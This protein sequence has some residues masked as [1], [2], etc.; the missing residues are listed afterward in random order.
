M[1]TIA[2]FES[3]TSLLRIHSTVLYAAAL[4][5]ALAVQDGARA[6]TLLEAPVASGGNLEGVWTADSMAF[7]V[8]TAPELAVLTAS[9]TPS[10]EPL[11]GL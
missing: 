7:E 3:R 11:V 2:E 4:F 10:A 8:Y 5:L 6:Q 1:K 9:L